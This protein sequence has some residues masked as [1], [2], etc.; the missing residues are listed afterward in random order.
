[1]R[2][3]RVWIGVVLLS[4]LWVGDQNSVVTRSR[5]PASQ[6]KRAI[7]SGGN[8]EEGEYSNAFMKEMA[9]AAGALATAGWSVESQFDGDTARCS[10]PANEPRCRTKAIRDKQ[11]CPRD[12]KAEDWTLEHYARLSGARP[13]DIRRGS[14]AELMAALDRALR[15]LSPGD[16][17][18]VAFHTH[19]AQERLLDAGKRG[20]KTRFAHALCMSDSQ[21]RVDDRELVSRFDQ[22]KT[23]GVRLGFIDSSCFS[24]GTLPHWASYGCVLTSNSDDRSSWGSVRSEST[25]LGQLAIQARSGGSLESVFVALLQASGRTN[26]PMISSFQEPNDERSEILGSTLNEFSRLSEIVMVVDPSRCKGCYEGHLFAAFDRIEDRLK[27]WPKAIDDPYESLVAE[28]RDVLSSL[29]SRVA[30]YQSLAANRPEIETQ[31]DRSALLVDTELTDELKSRV[32]PEKLSQ[33]IQSA[34]QSKKLV[35]LGGR[36][37]LEWR[38]SPISED[39]TDAIGISDV[40]VGE[41]ARIQGNDRAD[42]SLSPLIARWITLREGAAFARLTETE[43]Q[44]VTSLIRRYNESIEAQGNLNHFRFV[45]EA[46]SEI[47]AK[48]NDLRAQAFLR[49]SG[50]DNLCRQFRL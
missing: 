48:I 39:Y 31:L 30:R 32:D 5:K 9:R 3:L 49:S 10:I 44:V 12:F 13:E 28:I 36:L 34:I 29:R 35:R 37:S 50:E 43:Q 47:A 42:L 4:V 38:L 17:L 20:R 8:C 40:I 46:S 27:A 16:E 41:L 23:K 15:E 24:G 6:Q 11:C 45:T 18:L 1:M 2:D 19:G 22:L 14:K 33:A 26:T 25:L 21:M 7:I